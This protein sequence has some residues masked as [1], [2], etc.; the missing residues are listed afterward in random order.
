MPPPVSCQSPLILTLTL[1]KASYKLLTDLRS[2]YFPPHRNFLTAHVTLFHAIPL[3]RFDEL[4]E[5]LKGICAERNAWDVFIGEPQ[6]M[7]NR[8]VML[9]LRERPSNTT[10]QLHDQRL[11]WLKKGV[12]EDRDKLTNQDMQPLKRPHVT[13]LNKA[14]DEEQVD[15]CLKE[16]QEIF[17]GMKQEGQ[18]VG[19]HKGR[20]IGFEL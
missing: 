19:Q 15:T 10:A 17:D 2:K 20:A 18:S 1:D 9:N 8:G 7:G 14:R 11:R 3:H 5:R 12:H 13:V 16:V 6:K 4:D